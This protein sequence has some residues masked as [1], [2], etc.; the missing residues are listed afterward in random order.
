M[1]VWPMHAIDEVSHLFSLCVRAV[2]TV[3]N[4][5]VVCCIEGEIN[6][7]RW[8]WAMVGDITIV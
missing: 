1:G 7:M 3:G 5:I 8:W 4:G 6:V 2:E